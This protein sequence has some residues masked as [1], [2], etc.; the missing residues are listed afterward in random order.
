[1]IKINIRKIIFLTFGLTLIS[2]PIAY[3]DRSSLEGESLTVPRIDIEGSGSFELVF[4]LENDG[5]FKFVLEQSAASSAESTSAGSYDAVGELLILDQVE[6]ETKE[7]YSAALML[8]S[9]S[10]EVAFRVQDAALVYTALSTRGGV[11]PETTDGVPHFEIG[12]ELVPDVNTEMYRRVYSLPG[13]EQ[14]ASGGSFGGTQSIWLEDSVEF[15][16]S[17]VSVGGQEIGHIHPDGSLHLS[18]DPYRAV[19][20]HDSRFAIHHPWASE[21]REGW[22]GYV[23]I[24]TPR[25]IH[26]LDPVFQ[27]IVDSYNYFTGQNLQATD[28]Y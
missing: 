12:A 1:M 15:V 6:L 11:R 25:F 19:D 16:N 7:V 26:E 2:P 13:V 20:A 3:G 14:R 18:L 28:F 5:D 8:E 24:Y 4:R 22:E 17:E 27:M 9:Q 21:G 10:P 23:L